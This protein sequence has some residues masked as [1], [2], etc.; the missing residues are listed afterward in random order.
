M[1]TGSRQVRHDDAL[2]DAFER[3]LGALAFLRPLLNV[4]D[5]VFRDAA[6]NGERALVALPP[7]P[8]GL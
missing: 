2:E 8:V 1:R 7:V 5:Q 3:K 6:D 4:V